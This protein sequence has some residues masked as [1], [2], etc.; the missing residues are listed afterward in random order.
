MF[1]HI[2]CL[3][4]YMSILARHYLAFRSGL[5]E[6]KKPLVPR[7]KRMR[8][9]GSLLAA[10]AVVFVFAVRPQPVLAKADAENICVSVGRLLEEGH[11]TQQKLN[12]ELSRKFLHTYLELLDYSHLF[13]TKQDIDTLNAKYSSSLDDDVLLGN[14]KPAYEIYDLYAKRV[15]ERVAKVKEL[16]K[17]PIDFKTDETIELSRQKASLPQDDAESY[18][19]WRRYLQY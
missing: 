15:D 16:L 9:F 19:I 8:R 10:S 14:L 13:F 11:Y 2:G 6:H 5:C 4:S 7:M 12:D 3:T 17:Q 18:Q 1:V